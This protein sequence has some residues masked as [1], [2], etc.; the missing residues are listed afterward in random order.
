[1]SYQTSES[2]LRALLDNVPT[3]R[4]T[5][6]TMNREGIRKLAAE[7]AFSVYDHPPVWIFQKT[8]EY[9]RDEVVQLLGSVDLGQQMFQTPGEASRTPN[10]LF[11]SAESGSPAMVMTNRCTR[12][13]N[14][15]I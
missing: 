14:M 12:S 7:E 3:A 8:D 1:M 11:L 10:A 15:S 6:L 4:A 13:T 5:Q 2:Q 9:D